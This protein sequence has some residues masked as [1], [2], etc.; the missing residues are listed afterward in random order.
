MSDKKNINNNG[1]EL[2][3]EINPVE[4]E[5]PKERA[6]RAEVTHL[7]RQLREQNQTNDQPSEIKH[8]EKKEEFDAEKN[9]NEGKSCEE[10]KSELETAEKKMAEYLDGWKRAKADYLNLKKETDQRYQ[11]LIK[12]ANAGLILELL[13][14]LDNFKLAVLHIPES[15]KNAD[16]VIGIMHI[17]KQFQDILKTLGIEEIKTV[18]E[19]FNPE[20]HEAVGR[21]ENLAEGGE[22]KDGEEGKEEQSGDII[23][24]ELRAGYMLNGKII[25]AA[26]VI[27]E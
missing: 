23:V 21:E 15:E 20:L 7:R 17:K 5:T 26:K 1:E 4:G 16:W 24:K 9:E 11:E 10:L 13:P 14:V 25:Q 18:G 27:V 2:N 12:F 8:G 6:L 3:E 22:G 19:K